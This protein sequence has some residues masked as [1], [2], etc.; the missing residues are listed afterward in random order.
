MAEQISAAILQLYTSLCA[1]PLEPSHITYE[2]LE[3][4]VDNSIDCIDR[5]IVETH[6]EDCS[7]CKNEF[8]DLKAFV[9]TLISSV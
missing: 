2:S 6:L 5:E 8:Q 3:S 1:I 9:V 7:L 4:Y